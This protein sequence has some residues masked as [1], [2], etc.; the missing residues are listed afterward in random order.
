MA[1]TTQKKDAEKTAFVH[2][3]GGKNERR[4]N[5]DQFINLID[6]DSHSNICYI[7]FYD[8]SNRFRYA[9]HSNGRPE[10]LLHGL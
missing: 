3:G 5:F 1:Q 7:V 9:K 6:T 2:K 8:L 4:R 10:K